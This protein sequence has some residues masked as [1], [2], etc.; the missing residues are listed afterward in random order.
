MSAPAPWANTRTAAAD[1]GVVN[2]AETGPFSAVDMNVKEE[3]TMR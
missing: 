1:A 2:M 3:S